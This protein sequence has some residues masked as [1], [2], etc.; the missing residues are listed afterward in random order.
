MGQGANLA[1]RDPRAWASFVLIIVMG[2]TLDLGSKW[3][4]FEHVA[5]VPAHPDPNEVMLLLADDPAKVGLALPPHD[6]MPVIPGVLEFFLVLNP[7]AVF[8]AGPGQRWAFISFT[9]VTLLFAA[10][11][12]AC[13]TRRGQWLTQTALA[14]VIAGG[15]GNLYD[16]ITLGVVRDFLHFFPDTNL[17]FGLRWPSGNAELWPYISN[18]ADKFVLIGI[19]VLMVKLWR[20]DREAVNAAKAARAKG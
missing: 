16:R 11:V 17:P 8:G 4:C 12:F 14:L 19:A 20:V 7:G 5:E 10:Y 15:V 13:W 6:P 18:I 1:W 2:I 9:A 3:W